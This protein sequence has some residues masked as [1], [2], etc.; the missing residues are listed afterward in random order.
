MRRL[1]F[2]LA[3]LTFARQSAAQARDPAAFDGAS[4]RRAQ[5]PRVSSERDAVAPR[6]HWYGD[7]TLVVDA[8][9][10]S[11]VVGGAIGFETATRGRDRDAAS[12]VIIIGGLGLAAGAPVVHLAHGRPGAALG[13]LGLRV[14]L[15][16]GGGLTGALTGALVGGRSC[17]KSDADIPPCVVVGELLGGG[18]GVIAA[19]A[20]DASTLAYE[21]ALAPVVGYD[22]RAFSLGIQGTF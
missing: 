2:A 1:L 16:L 17:T 18:A 6:E 11:L 4:Q 22:G 3:V 19:A 8:I 13:S 20:I 14:G 7:Q 21:P 12:A 9:A 15:A 10:T 5:A